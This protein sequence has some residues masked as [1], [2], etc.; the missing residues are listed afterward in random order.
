MSIEAPTTDGSSEDKDM[1][2]AKAII[3]KSSG[4]E[5]K[6]HNPQEKKGGAFSKNYYTYEI[7]GKEKK[8]SISVQRRYKEFDALRERLK[9]NWPGIFIPALPEKKLDKN[10][11]KIIK[12]RQIFLNHFMKKCAKMDHIFYSE[13]MQ[14]FLRST[15]SSDELLKNLTTMAPKTAS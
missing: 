5:I 14:I 11:N 4:I 3:E 6:V 1:E 12:E 15:G 8:G 10:N 2:I 13:E 7:S 9:L